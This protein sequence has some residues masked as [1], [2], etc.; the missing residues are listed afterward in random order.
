[1]SAHRFPLGGLLIIL[2]CLFLG[3]AI[4]VLSGLPVPGSVLGMLIFLAYL[5][6]RKPDARSGSVRAADGLLANM[7][8]FF[9]P[10]GVGIV[11]HLALLRTEWLAA[12][13]GFFASWVAALVAAVASTL[14]Y[15]FFFT[16]PYRTL[17]ANLA[18]GAGTRAGK[19][20]N[21]GRVVMGFNFHQYM[22]GLLSVFVGLGIRVW[23]ETSGFM[24]HHHCRIVSIGG[25]YIF[26]AHFVGVLDHLEQRGRLLAAIDRPAG[27]EDLVPA[28][29]GIGL[30]EH[31]QLDVVRVAAKLGVTIAQVVDLVLRQCQ[32]QPRVRRFQLAERDHLERTAPLRRE[33]RRAILARCQ[34]RLRHRIVQQLADRRLRSGIVRPAGKV[35]AHAA[36][37]DE[38]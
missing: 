37:D 31:H 17:I 20:R 14:A 19:R 6:W 29:L 23:M 33:Q 15:N 5:Q 9:I 2:A 38:G 25:Q 27:I 8:L 18:T 1:M 4:T 3:S 32:A 22:D 36:L 30:R 34:Q 12:L 11:A 16:A 10:P 35:D 21:S 7:Q 26:T 13:G 24:A 28:M